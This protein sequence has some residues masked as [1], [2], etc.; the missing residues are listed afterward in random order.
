MG[1]ETERD[2]KKRLVDAQSSAPRSEWRQRMDE[3]QE[4]ER[5]RKKLR[6]VER[7]IMKQQAR[8]LAKLD[9][10]VVSQMSERNLKNYIAHK[11]YKTNLKQVSI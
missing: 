7:L 2:R 6:I 5:I 9:S 1:F 8:R 10:C 11:G 4:I 3:L